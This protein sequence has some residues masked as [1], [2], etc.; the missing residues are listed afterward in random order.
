MYQFIGHQSLAYVSYTIIQMGLC[1]EYHS[2]LPFRLVKWQWE[3]MVHRM[4]QEGCFQL[5]CLVLSW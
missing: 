3:D 1:Y 5:H 4:Y 2:E